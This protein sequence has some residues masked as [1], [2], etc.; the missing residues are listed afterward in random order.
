MIQGDMEGKQVWLVVSLPLQD[1]CLLDICLLDILI[2]IDDGEDD[3]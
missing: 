1:D 2:Y 3:I